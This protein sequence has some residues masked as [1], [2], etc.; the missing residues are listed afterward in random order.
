MDLAYTNGMTEESMKDN[1][2]T[3]ICTVKEHISGQMDVCTKV[4][5]STTKKMDMVFIHTLIRGNILVCGHKVFNMEKVLLD[6]QQELN[7]KVYGKMVNV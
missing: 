1:G 5:T 6:H 4:P 7:V 3:M 2:K